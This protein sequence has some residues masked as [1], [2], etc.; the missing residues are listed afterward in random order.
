MLSF[1]FWN[2]NKNNWDE[3]SECMRTRIRRLVR[4]HDLDVLV[5]AESA[6]EP[7][8]VTDFLNELNVGIY[9]HSENGCPGIQCYHRLSRSRVEDQFS[10]P[11]KRLAIRRLFVRPREILLVS[12][13]APSQLHRTLSEI[14]DAITDYRSYIEQVEDLLSTRRTIVMGDMNVNPFDEGMVSSQALHAVMLKDRARR[15]RRRVSGVDRRFFYNPMWG[16]FGDRTP[17]PPGTFHYAKSTPVMY[18]WNMFDQV[19]LRP[20]VMD[21]V[22]DLRILD[23]DGEGSLLNSQELPDAKTA[24]DHLPI[25]LQM[26][27]DAKDERL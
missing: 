7:S 3:R 19:L 22:H 2:L 4:H 12:L 20:S 15:E 9:A 18:Y 26:S 25:Y 27:F 11:D 16:F 17:G 23:H 14:K 1:L 10:S 13:H 21:D 5:F 24:S 6:F 8:V